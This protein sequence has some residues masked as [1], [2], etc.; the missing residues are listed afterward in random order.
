MAVGAPKESPV[1]VLVVGTGGALVSGVSTA[2]DEMV[3]GARGDGTCGGATDAR[4][5]SVGAVPTP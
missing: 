5:P 3:R 1:K 4:E 2:A